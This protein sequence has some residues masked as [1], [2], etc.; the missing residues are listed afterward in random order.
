MKIS[1]SAQRTLSLAVFLPVLAVVLILRKTAHHVFG[2]DLLQLG[3]HATDVYL[4][5]A[6]GLGALFWLG[7]KKD[8][9]EI[10]P[11]PS[12]LTL[13]ATALAVTLLL[14]WKFDSVRGAVGPDWASLYFLV[15]AF[16]AFASSFFLLI[17]WRAVVAKARTEPTRVFFFILGA[18]LLVAYPIVLEMAWKPMALWT[19]KACYHLL[20]V[21]GIS[22]QKPLLNNSLRL[23]NPNFS[24]YMNMGCSGLEGIFFFLSGF[25]L[26]SAYEGKPLSPIRTPLLCLAGCL[27]MMSL[28]IFRITAVF[29]GG[30]IMETYYTNK[31]ARELFEWAFHANVGWTLYLAGMYWFFTRWVMQPEAKVS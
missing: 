24:A 18:Q 23:W 20:Q 28:N 8:P 3:V 1:E 27:L 14:A 4:P 12:A 17:S 11:R 26:V 25:V 5:L 19:G 9:L 15:A 30:V 22:V 10:R 29:G 7:Q 6:L 31:G 16:V 21:L 13:A 2:K